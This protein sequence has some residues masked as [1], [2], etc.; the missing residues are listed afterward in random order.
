MTLSSKQRAELRGEAHH[1]NPLVHVGHQGLTDTL[2]QTIDD[3]LRT[4]E[5]VKI[6]LTKTAD[7]KPKDAAGEIAEKL[8]ADVVQTIGRTCTLYRHNPDLHKP[9]TKQASRKPWALMLLLSLGTGM[10]TRA[11]AQLKMDD[12]KAEGPRVFLNTAMPTAVRSVIKV[13]PGDNLQAALDRAQLGDVIELASGAVFTGNFVLRDKGA[14]NGWI[15]IRPSNAARLPAEGTRMTPQTAA[16]LALPRIITPNSDSP[17]ATAPAAHHW[18]LTGVE[19]TAN[20]ATKQVWALVNFDGGPSQKTMD[21]VPHDL[22]LDRAYVHGSAALS[23]RRCVAL[24]SA[25]SAIVD[26]WLSDCHEAGADSQAIAGWNGPGPFKIVNNYLEG[27]GENLIFGGADPG[28]PGLTPSDIEIR[29]NHFYKQ[30][31]WKKVWLVK[32]LL[33]LKHA[34]RVIIEGN[35]LENSWLHG[36]DGVAIAIKTV[37]QDGR[38][39]WCVTQDVTVRLN[40]IRN[41]GA[42]VNIAGSPD[43]AFQDIPARRIVIADNAFVGVNAPGFDGSARGFSIYG[44]ASD[45]VIAHNAMLSPSSCA[46]SFGPARTFIKGFS[47]HDNVVATGEYGIVGQ[48]YAGGGALRAYTPY[49]IFGR[50]V[51]VGSASIADFPDGNSRVGKLDEVGFVDPANFDFHLA[52]SSRFRGKGT[53]GSD[54]GPDAGALLAAIAGVVVR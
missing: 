36:Q 4:H 54:P 41:V 34:Q 21:R 42:G 22:V 39:T 11:D 29:R 45:V 13:G 15:V 26:S 48:D 49:G 12:A 27:A 14:G 44:S 53:A 6:A 43:N 25:S 38:C 46:F 17:I 8:S 23:L 30:V 37:N 28:V 20:P 2:L 47:A 16:A 3:A 32:N 18:R 50:N 1:L 51:L 7:V 33:E 9:G 10:A 24:N 5:L 19:I 40:A 52:S 35:V 31:S